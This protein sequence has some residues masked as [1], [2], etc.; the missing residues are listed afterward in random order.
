M[1]TGESI[2]A[3]AKGGPAWQRSRLKIEAA[4]PESPEGRLIP[5]GEKREEEMKIRRISAFIFTS[6]SKCRTRAGSTSNSKFRIMTEAGG[7]MPLI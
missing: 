6:H 2:E 4:S 3:G 5:I 7:A 1:I